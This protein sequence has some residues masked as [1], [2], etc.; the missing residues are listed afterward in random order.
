[1]AHSMT[2]AAEIASTRAYEWSSWDDAR[3]PIYN[4]KRWLMRRAAREDK[5]YGGTE[6][7]WV[8]SPDGAIGVLGDAESAEYAQDGP[9]DVEWWF[10]TPHQA[11]EDLPRWRGD[12]GL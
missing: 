3:R 2:E 11:Y 4:S 12:I 7:D 5:K 6:L 1:M 9:R 10:F 8:V